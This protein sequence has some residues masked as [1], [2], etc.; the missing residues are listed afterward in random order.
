M[1]NVKIWMRKRC[2]IEKRAKKC[3][4]PIKMVV[5]GASFAL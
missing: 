4:L 2:E 5:F 1:L 3:P